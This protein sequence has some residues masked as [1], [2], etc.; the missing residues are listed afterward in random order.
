[1]NTKAGIAL[2]MLII[3]GS[4]F[5]ADASKSPNTNHSKKSAP[6]P[7]TIF[8]R[9]LQSTTIVQG[10]Q[11]LSVPPVTYTSIDSPLKFTCPT[12][13]CTVSVEVNAQIGGSTD[14]SNLFAVCGLLD[15]NFMP[16]PGNGEGCPYVGETLVDGGYSAGT[17]VFTQSGVHAGNHTLQSQ[18]FVADGAVLANYSI[19]YRLYTP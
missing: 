7:T 12:G 3:C 19:T 5:A 1:M 13:G 4:A 6:P 8:N 14:A 9:K 10:E 16:P 2:A 15:G 18:I 11:D 17:F